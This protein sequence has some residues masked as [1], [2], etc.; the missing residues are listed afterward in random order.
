[1]NGSLTGYADGVD[2][3]HNSLEIVG[4]NMEK[5]FVPAKGTTV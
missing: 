3:K 2:K 1:M 4:V 5:L